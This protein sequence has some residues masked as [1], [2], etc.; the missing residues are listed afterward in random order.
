MDPWRD[1]FWALLAIVVGVPLLI[2]VVLAL[3]FLPDRPV[4]YADIEEHFKYGSIGSEPGGSLF[5]TIGGALPAL[6]WTESIGASIELMQEFAERAGLETTDE[7][8]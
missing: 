7:H 4:T 6:F 3:R 2:G 5:N 1:R 8:R